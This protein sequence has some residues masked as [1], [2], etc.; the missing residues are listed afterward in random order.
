LIDVSAGQIDS[1]GSTR[2]AGRQRSTGDV[3]AIPPS[4]AERTAIA[5]NSRPPMMMM[6]MMMTRVSRHTRKISEV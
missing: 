6:M 5:S 1:L 4:S 3:G 2:A